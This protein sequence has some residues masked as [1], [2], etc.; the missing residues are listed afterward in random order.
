MV[1]MG[2]VRVA[3]MMTSAEDPARKILQTIH[4]VH[5]LLEQSAADDDGIIDWAGL[6]RRLDDDRSGTMEFDELLDG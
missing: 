1:E 4:N 6:F 2:V 3:V 5:D